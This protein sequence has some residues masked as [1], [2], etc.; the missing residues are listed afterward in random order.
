MIGKRS[1]LGLTLV[2]GGLLCVPLGS[3]V[4]KSSTTRINGLTACQSAPSVVRLSSSRPLRSRNV[5][6]FSQFRYRM[7][8][9]LGETTNPSPEEADLG[10]AVIPSRHVSSSSHEMTCRRHP[11]VHP[12]RC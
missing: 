2:F 7:K 11:S 4:S 1:A 6:R 9:V 5:A 10:L 8:S 3:H 12:L